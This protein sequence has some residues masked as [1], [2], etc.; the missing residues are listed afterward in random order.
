MSDVL[1]IIQSKVKKFLLITCN[2]QELRDDEEI[3]RSGV[4]NSLIA[5]QLVMFV[6]EEF[7]ITVENED[8]D[9][10]KFKCVNSITSLIVQKMAENGNSPGGENFN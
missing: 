10:D 7:G 5:V 4:I 9:I 6:E 3:F 8:L 2:L 1:S